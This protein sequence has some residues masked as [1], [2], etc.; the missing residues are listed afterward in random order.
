MRTMYDST[1]PFDIPQN[2]RMVAGYVDG[3]YAWSQAGWDRFPDA[4]KVTIS[5]VGARTAHVGDVERGC[6]W[7][8]SNAVPWVRRA[9]ADGYDPTIY[10]NELNDWGPC[11]EAFRLAGEPEPHWWVARYNGVAQVPAGAVARQYAH[12]VDS[13]GVP[14]KP[15]ETGFHYDLS[16]VLDYWPGV[17][18]RAPG[19]GDTEESEMG[20]SFGQVELPATNATDYTEREVI[21]PDM[22]GS[23][24]V[25][26][27][28]VKIHGPGQPFIDSTQVD[29]REAMVRLAHFLNDAGDI[30]GE[31]L[32]AGV[33]LEHHETAP[34]AQ[35]PTSATKLVVQ[36][37]SVVGL[38]V[39]VQVKSA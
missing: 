39:M 12:P 10:V 36:Y 9:R 15:W 34:G 33:V 21:F 7:P 5:A 13:D 29:R 6:I 22:G 16:A 27:R 35:I 19:G 17:D 1:N 4:V 37:N 23:M 2:A 32:P 3:R 14:D 18:E 24:Q 30:V 38:N 25:V 26:D 28:W 20:F 31:Y 11:R 8:V